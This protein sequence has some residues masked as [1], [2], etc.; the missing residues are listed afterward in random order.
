MLA[1]VRRQLSPATVMAFVALVFA[2]TGGAFAVTG[3]GGH[4]PAASP[5]S[6]SAVATAA[7]SKSKPK[8]KAGPRGPAGPAGA[9]GPA[10]PAGATG[11][12]GPAGSAGAAGAKGENGAAGTNGTNGT[13][14][15][16]VTSIESKTKIGGPCGA[17]G[18]SFTSA[19]GK[20]YACDGKEGS[21]WTANGML[22]V[23][24]TETG[25]W[26]AG[27]VLLKRSTENIF[28]KEV[29]SFPIRLAAPMDG[30]HVHYINEAGQEVTET[31][32]NEEGEP[33]GEETTA[34]TACPGSIEKPEAVSGNLC[35]YGTDGTSTGAFELQI[36]T[37]AGGGGA[38]T[39]GAELGF[40]VNEG[41]EPYAQGTWAVTG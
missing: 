31:T 13:N 19:S 17:G 29:I 28:I 6:A 4:S 3:R 26:R 30:K 36:T 21:P 16:S 24:A 9:Q 10:G 18:S 32:F 2:T 39:T 40:Y 1:W 34:Q 20:T 15:T 27:S 37:P 8:V 5:G 25:A 22:P 12:Q 11:P 7:K 33:V 41:R 35:I 14:G 23:G 38:G